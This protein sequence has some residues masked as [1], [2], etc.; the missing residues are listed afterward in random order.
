MAAQIHEEPENQLDLLLKAGTGHGFKAITA[1]LHGVVTA[2]VSAFPRAEV[3]LSE[4]QDATVL[5]LIRKCIYRKKRKAHHSRAA[6]LSDWSTD[7][8]A[9]VCTGA[10]YTAVLSV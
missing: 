6:P 8:R 9:R 1:A 2:F 3:S 4:A 7:S 5:F 10:V